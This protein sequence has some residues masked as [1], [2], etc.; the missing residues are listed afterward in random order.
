MTS[1][2]WRI[3]R[4]AVAAAALL[5]AMEAHAALSVIGPPQDLGD[6]SFRF[7]IGLDESIV[8]DNFSG[9]LAG[10][11]LT[12]VAVPDYTILGTPNLLGNQLF[13]DLPATT[14]FSPQAPAVQ[15]LLQVSLIPGDAPSNLTVTFESLAADP[16]SR[17]VTLAVPEPNAYALLL[18]GLGMLMAW[19]MRKSI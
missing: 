11:T 1:G 14:T 5:F 13:V 10:G 16:V 15:R 18:A 17:D 3:A 8:A 2:F 7:D 6:G 9:G 19:R 12:D 4:H